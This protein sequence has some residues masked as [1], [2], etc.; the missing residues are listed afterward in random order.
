MYL[1]NSPH[2]SQ[3]RTRIAPCGSGDVVRTDLRE[4]RHVGLNQTPV[5]R[6]ASSH[7]HDGRASDAGTVKMDAVTSH[8]DQFPKWRI[9]RRR[10]RSALIES[11]EEEQRQNEQNHDCHARLYYTAIVSEGHRHLISGYHRFHA[12]T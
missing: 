9:W 3:E 2:A 6:E 7:N 8:V 12:C 11:N 4:L 5:E 10:L 1:V